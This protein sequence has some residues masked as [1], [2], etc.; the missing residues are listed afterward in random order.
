M[1]RGLIPEPVGKRSDRD[2]FRHEGARRHAPMPSAGDVH[3]AIFAEAS[4]PQNG[5]FRVT[6]EAM[7]DGSV[8]L[9]T[10]GPGPENTS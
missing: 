7:C 5:L 3:S 4:L 10:D 8:N 2:G 1:G 6:G 9:R